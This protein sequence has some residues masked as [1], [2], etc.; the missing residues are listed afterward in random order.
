[1]PAP[2]RVCITGVGAVSP[3]GR[4]AAELWRGLLAGRSAVAPIASFDASDLA[5]RIAAEVRDYAPREDM[6][7]DAA[8]AMDRRALFASDA[9][10]QALIEADVPINAETVTQIG[11]AA[12]S[13]LPPGATTPAAFVA[14]TISAAGPVS[15][16]A[17]AAASGLMAIGEAAEWI[18]RD[19]CS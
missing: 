9:A 2:K 15:H 11:V 14:R 19:E 5:C 13:E 18:R 7:P 12:G 4:S 3:F 10:I 16:L 6:A 1:M 17:N 8:A